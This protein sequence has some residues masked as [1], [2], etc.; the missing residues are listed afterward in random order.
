VSNITAFPQAVS[1]R[2]RITALRGLSPLLT[3]DFYRAFDDE[4]RGARELIKS[5]LCA[6]PTVFSAARGDASGLFSTWAMV[7]ARLS[8]KHGVLRYGL[9]NRYYQPLNVAS[10][11]D[12]DVLISKVPRCSKRNLQC[13]GR[14]PKKPKITP[15]SEL[16]MKSALLN[17]GGAMKLPL[18]ENLSRRQFNLTSLI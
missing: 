9:A 4:H 5:R 6:Y 11:T 7:E 10:S 17:A 16:S 14:P 13:C 8:M 12:V 2:C 3:A 1:P 18:G 15:Q